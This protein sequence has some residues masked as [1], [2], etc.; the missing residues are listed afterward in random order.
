MLEVHDV[1]GTWSNHK[2]S[3]VTFQADGSFSAAGMDM[4]PAYEGCGSVSGTGS[5]G[6]VTAQGDSAPSGNVDLSFGGQNDSCDVTFTSWEAGSPV[7]LCIDLDP[8]SPCTGTP[9]TKEH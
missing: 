6:F 1:V 4:D 2:G 9:W 8:D 5:W 3:A 7:A